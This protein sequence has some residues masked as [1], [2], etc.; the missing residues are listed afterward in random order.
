[1]KHGIQTGHRTWA[2]LGLLA[3]ALLASS[4]PATASPDTAN[5]IQGSPDIGDKKATLS[6]AAN[7][8]LGATTPID[9]SG[10]KLKHE[11]YDGTLITGARDKAEGHCHKFG[12]RGLT[13]TPH[14]ARAP[15]QPEP[16]R[17]PRCPVAELKK[18][19]DL[20]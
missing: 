14:A 11:R 12:R 17:R 1:M 20:N 16:G 7:Y 2:H 13:R 6:G 9:S 3:M 18:P 19:A 15:R 5:D 10:T 8:D 4:N